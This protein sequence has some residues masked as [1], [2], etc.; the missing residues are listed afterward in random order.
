[1]GPNNVVTWSF[2]IVKDGLICV[3]DVRNGFSVLRYTRPTDARCATSSSCARELLHRI[4]VDH[5]PPL[6]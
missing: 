2:P 4:D 3:V 5:L 6:V 1:M